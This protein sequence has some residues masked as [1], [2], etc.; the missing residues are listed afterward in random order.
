MHLQCCIFHV[1]YVEKVEFFHVKTCRDAAYVVFPRKTFP[2][3][4]FGW[5]WGGWGWREGGRGG[6][7]RGARERE[8]RVGDW[9]GVR[10]E[11]EKRRGGRVF[12][13]GCA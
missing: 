6:G 8:G 13:L 3:E 2:R 7:E 5:N 9:V 1:K 4:I 11:K 12:G 10:N